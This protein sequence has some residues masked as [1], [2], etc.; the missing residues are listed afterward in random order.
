M[1][2]IACEPTLKFVSESCAELPETV[3]V[4]SVVELVVS[5]KVTVPVA[6]AGAWG[7]ILAVS[8]T[9]VP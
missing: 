9:G 1:A 4:P 6:G 5:V 8:V 3:A 7:W 2:A